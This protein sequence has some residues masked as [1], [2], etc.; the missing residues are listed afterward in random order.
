MG[1]NL[2]HLHGKYE[3]GEARGMVIISVKI[4]KQSRIVYIYCEEC[5][6][7]VLVQHTPPIVFVGNLAIRERTSGTS[8][9][10]KPRKDRPHTRR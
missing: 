1:K 10:K 3:R 4:F 9:M 2:P 5:T 7:L 6:S 8:L